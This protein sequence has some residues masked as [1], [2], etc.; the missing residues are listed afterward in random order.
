[1]DGVLR[2]TTAALVLQGRGPLVVVDPWTA[3]DGPDRN[4]P[5]ERARYERRFDALAA[6]G[7]KPD[8]VD[9]VVNTHLDGVGSNTTPGRDREERVAFTTAT[10]SVPRGEVAALTEGKRPNAEAVRAVLEQTT[11]VDAPLALDDDIT[12]VAA[13]GHTPDHTA[14]RVSSRGETAYLI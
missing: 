2:V 8:D 11:A 1:G 12:I 6:A 9:A 3:L 10:Y 13:P 4:A 5:E 7:M 14:V